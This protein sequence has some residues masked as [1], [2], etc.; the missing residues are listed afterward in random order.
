MAPSHTANLQIGVP[1][2]FVVP[3]N[4][5]CFFARFLCWANLYLH[6]LSFTFAAFGKPGGKRLRQTLRVDATAVLYLAFSSRKSVI[7]LG[8]AREIA[9]REAIQQIERA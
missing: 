2:F 7:K 9:H 3:V 1:V 4:D 8:R 5:A 6:R